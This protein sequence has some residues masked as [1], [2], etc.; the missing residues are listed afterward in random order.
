MMIYMVAFYDNTFMECKGNYDLDILKV[1]DSEEKAVDY[2]HKEYGNE[3]GFHYD[4]LCE[5]WR[6]TIETKYEDTDQYI[7]IWGWDVE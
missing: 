4:E 6:F 1:F 7:E 5:C 3:N 2:I